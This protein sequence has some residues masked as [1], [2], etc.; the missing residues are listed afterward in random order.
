[1][2]AAAPTPAAGQALTV[3]AIIDLLRQAGRH[4]YLSATA[5][6]IYRILQAEHLQARPQIAEAY[7]AS[8]RALSHNPPEFLQTTPRL[9]ATPGADLM[10]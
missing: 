7:G 8:T 6:K 4:R 9:S 10:T 1:V 5:E 3:E 2:L